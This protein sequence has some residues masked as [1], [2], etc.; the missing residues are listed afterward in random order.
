M[1]TTTTQN[2]NTPPLADRVNSAVSSM[3]KD[4]A[5]NWTLPEDESAPN[6]EEFKYAV[7]AERRVRD[8]QS[9]YTKS[10]QKV[11]ELE[12][13]N[14]A[15]TDHVIAS[16]TVNLTAEQRTELDSLRVDDPEAWRLKLSG[17]EAEAVA[18]Q[19]EKLTEFNSQGVQASKADEVA[20]AYA[21]F[22]ATTGMALSDDIIDNDLPASFK[23]D[24]EG[25]IIDL[26][27]FIDKAAQYLTKSKV[28]KGADDTTGKGTDMSKLAGGS[29]PTQTAKDVD[30]VQTYESEIF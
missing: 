11:K 9:G 13:V 27:Q 24:F 29:E 23:R 19:K 30:S 25:G 22:T 10:R 17:Y 26:S 20:Q 28:I 16:A 8:T 3:V 6:S 7:L 2:E 21:D 12:T 18:A 1:A 5:G 4:D 15:L 14:T